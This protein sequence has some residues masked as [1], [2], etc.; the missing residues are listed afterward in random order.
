VDEAVGKAVG[1]ASGTASGT[2]GVRNSGVA[3][4]RGDEVRVVAVTDVENDVAKTVV[5]MMAT[6]RREVCMFD[7]SNL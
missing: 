2:R 1:T 6:V 3:S 5:A 7:L 4:A